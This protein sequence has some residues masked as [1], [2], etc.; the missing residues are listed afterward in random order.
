MTTPTTRDASRVLA[1]LDIEL[2]ADRLADEIERYLTDPNRTAHPLVTLPTTELVRQALA[3]T[4]ATPVHTP[5]AAV[6]SP[7][8]GI[9]R[10]LPDRLLLL[11]RP[12]GPVNYRHLTVGEHLELTAAVL[13][14]AGWAR[15]GRRAR[16]LTGRRCILGAQVALYAMGY[17]DRETANAAGGYLNRILRDRGIREDYSTWNERVDR[18]QAL[19][20]V[21]EAAA[22]ANGGRR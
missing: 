3:A 6:A 14:H 16:T 1:D 2:D 12:R 9:W 21:R 11:S 22:I 20:L 15:T 5:A 18:K 7:L 8:R 17:G 4:S 10:V 13:E 19:K